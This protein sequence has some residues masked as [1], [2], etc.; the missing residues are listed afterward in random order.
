MHGGCSPNGLRRPFVRVHQQALQG[1]EKERFL[2]AISGNFLRAE[3]H[4]GERRRHEQDRCGDRTAVAMEPTPVVERG[5]QTLVRAHQSLLG[6]R[7]FTGDFGILERPDQHLEELP[8]LL[9]LEHVVV[10]LK[11]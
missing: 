8:D 5:G 4:S 9:A 3:T 11:R 2:D 1:Q 7:Q 10:P 6:R